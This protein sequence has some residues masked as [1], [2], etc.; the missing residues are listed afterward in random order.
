MEFLTFITQFAKH[1]GMVGSIVPSSKYLTRRMLAP[2]NWQE[3]RVVI[4]LGCGTGAITREIIKRLHK[5]PTRITLFERN[6]N[7]RSLLKKR[8]PDLPIYEDAQALNTV[9]KS[10]NKKADVIISSLPFSNFPDVQQDFILQEV[11]KALDDEG[12]FIT[13]QYSL[14]M[15]QKLEQCFSKMSV[16][17]EW[18]NI[19]PAWIYT[20]TK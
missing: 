8:Y 16:Q 18:I 17:L 13:Y 1:P 12:I 14:Q 20:C 4:E 19:P 10:Q 9:L 15:R 11:H 6:S 5:E 2:V 7:F 3:V